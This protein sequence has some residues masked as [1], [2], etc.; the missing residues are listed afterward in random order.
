M[1][2]LMKFLVG[3]LSVLVLV[4][5]NVYVEVISLDSVM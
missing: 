1:K 5:G 3:V 4:V 2:I